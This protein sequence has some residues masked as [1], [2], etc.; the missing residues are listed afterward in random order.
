MT[1]AEKVAVLKAKA[2]ALVKTFEGRALPGGPIKIK[3]YATILNNEKYLSSNAAILNGTDNPF[4][5]PYVAA[6]R[7]LND[8]KKY[9]DEHFPINSQP[10]T[11]EDFAKPRD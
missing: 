8:L 9:L 7:R 3:S 11:G 5:K 1:R 10:S 4:S 6:F 2:A